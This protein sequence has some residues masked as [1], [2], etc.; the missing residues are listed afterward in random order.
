MADKFSGTAPS[1]VN[2]V[3]L[4]EIKRLMLEL[5]L[6]HPEILD[7][8]NFGGVDELMTA[9]LP[10][11][12]VELATAARTYLEDQLGSATSRALLARRLEGRGLSGG[13]GDALSGRRRRPIGRSRQQR[14]RPQPLPRS[15]LARPEVRQ[16]QWSVVLVRG[17][18]VQ[19]ATARR[20]DCL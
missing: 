15:T 10:E 7:V 13:L 12:T 6:H 20:T 14:L 8:M 16:P 9:V 17:S 19:T 5:G 1:G 4:V 2:V 11:R 3:S 18:A